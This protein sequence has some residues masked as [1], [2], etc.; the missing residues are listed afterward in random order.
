VS[1]SSSPQVPTSESTPEGAAPDGHRIGKR[2][3]TQPQLKPAEGRLSAYLPSY[4]ASSTP[5]ALRLHLAS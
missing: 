4:P 2:G 5:L 1:S 3:P